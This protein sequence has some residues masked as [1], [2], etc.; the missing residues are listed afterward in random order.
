MHAHI[1]SN[2]QMIFVKRQEIEEEKK[3]GGRN[4]QREERKA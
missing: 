3:E 4:E 1:Y 2:F